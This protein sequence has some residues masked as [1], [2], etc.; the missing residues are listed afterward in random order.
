MIIIP[1]NA[2][3]IVPFL[4]IIHLQQ[5]S[6][7]KKTN[8][9]DAV[10]EV[11]EVDQPDPEVEERVSVSDKECGIDPQSPSHRHPTDLHVQRHGCPHVRG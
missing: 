1:D 10:D 11:V 9:R 5:S 2:I 8:E 7:G 4:I 6:D 3:I